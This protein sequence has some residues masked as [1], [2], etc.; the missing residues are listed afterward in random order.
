MRRF[1]VWRAARLLL[2]LS[3]FAATLVWAA[4]GVNGQETA[5]TQTQTPTPAPTQS[6]TS[7]DSQPAN[8]PTAPAPET[9][10]ATPAQPAP[11]VAAPLYSEYKG[12]KIGTTRDEAR[13]VLGSPREKDKQQDFFLLSDRE[14]VRVYYDDKGAASAVIVTYVGKSAGA[15]APKDILGAEPEQKQDGSIYEL[16]R[17][18]E[19]G[20]WIAYSRTAGD[21]PLTIITMQRMAS[22]K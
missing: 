15:P 14:R 17:Y 21:E 2:A 5:Q 20:Y 11:A 9:S 13:K 19:A 22:N 6:G 4:A 10:P 7:D 3:L 12:V 18:P 8:Q 1:F 16:V